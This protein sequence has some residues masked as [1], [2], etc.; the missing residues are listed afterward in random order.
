MS[1]S[2]EHTKK[3]CSLITALNVTLI[4][5]FIPNLI[6]PERV[7]TF[8]WKCAHCPLLSFQLSHLSS[9]L[10]HNIM[11]PSKC[12]HNNQCASLLLPWLHSALLFFIDFSGFPQ[13]WSLLFHKLEIVNTTVSPFAFLL[14]VTPSAAAIIISSP[15]TKLLKPSLTTVK[16]VKGSWSWAHTGCRESRQ[17]FKNKLQEF[18]EMCLQER[19][20]LHTSPCPECLL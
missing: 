2:C 13:I 7:F 17:C 4:K 10:L 18:F 20:A 8:L 16:A 6:A 9:C 5:I 1:C 12:S 14:H 11:F 19:L 3:P 15:H